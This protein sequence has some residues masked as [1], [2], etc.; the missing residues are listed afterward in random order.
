MGDYNGKLLVGYKE[1][2]QE[3]FKRHNSILKQQN[4]NTNTVVD[5]NNLDLFYNQD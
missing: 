1:S 2:N 4:G 5:P 3:D